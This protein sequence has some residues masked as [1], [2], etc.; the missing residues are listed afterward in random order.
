MYRQPLKAGNSAASAAQRMICLVVII[1]LFLSWLVVLVFGTRPET[2]R[3]DSRFEHSGLENLAKV[4]HD[5]YPV[6]LRLLWRS[7]VLGITEDLA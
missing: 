7:P 2:N 3:N 5:A 1:I 6:F 4:G